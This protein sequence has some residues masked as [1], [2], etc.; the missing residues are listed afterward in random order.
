MP[1]AQLT[2]GGSVDRE[3]GIAAVNPATMRDLTNVLP[4]SGK[5]QAREGM[6][7]ISTLSYGGTEASAVVLMEPIVSRQEALAVGWFAATRQLRIFRLSGL[8]GSPTH[9]GLWATLPVGSLPKVSSAENFS[10]IL[11][12]HDEPVVG[13][14]ATTMVYNV[15]GGT[16]TPLKA[17][18]DEVGEAD[19]KFRV[20]K[21][22]GDYMAGTGFGSALEDHPEY[23]RLSL[24]GQPAAF[25]KH[26][27]FV[28]G[29][30]GEPVAALGEAGSSL[31]VFKGSR[32]FRLVG[33]T[34]LNFGILPLYALVGCPSQRLVVTVEQ[35]CYFW[36]LDGPR[37]SNGADAPD[38]GRVLDLEGPQPD[39]LPPGLGIMDGVAFYRPKV[40]VVEWAF[41]LTTYA[42][43]LEGEGLKWAFGVRGVPVGSASILYSGGAQ[44]DVT[45]NQP[46]TSYSSIT[47]V[48]AGGSSATLT[49][50]NSNV[51]SNTVGEVWLRP[52]DGTWAKVSEFTV[53]SGTQTVKVASLTPI[54]GYEVAV[55]HRRAGVY[56]PGYT[57]LDPSGWPSVSRATFSTTLSAPV[58]SSAVWERLSAFVERVRV[59]FVPADTAFSHQVLRNGSVVA[60]LGPGVTRLDTSNF[61]GESWTSWTVRAVSGVYTS[62]D[63]NSIQVWT[64]PV[65]A[66]VVATIE[67]EDGGAPCGD[68]TSPYKLLW[69]AG[70]AGASTVVYVNNARTLDMPSGTYVTYLC[71]PTEGVPPTVEVAHVVVT[72]STEDFTPRT[73]ASLVAA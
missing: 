13:N 38:I 31:L 48:A 43:S 45:A 47:D 37:V 50:S 15:F 72:Q 25:E 11:L 20:V 69:T 65:P 56:T 70:I 6:A 63:S 12:A 26:H 34:P 24:P 57:S 62:S 39:H 53:E 59:D 35:Q 9:I 10:T 21:Q 1:S 58:L 7:L 71:L 8:G 46:P 68:G 32:T 2:F 51:L 19:V 66:P 61:E 52:T 40:R 30:R 64:G 55:R 29:A 73:R 16:L 54:Q 22:W 42:L 44:L 67:F 41:G 23:L 4:L 17:S 14:R 28:V 3:T 27:Y 49:L 5:A 33:E 18:F 36:S 60:T